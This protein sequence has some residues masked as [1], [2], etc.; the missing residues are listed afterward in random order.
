MRRNRQEAAVTDL[1][2]GGEADWQD[3]PPVR[4]L[5]RFWQLSLVMMGVGDYDG[6]YRYLNRAYRDVLGWSEE[7]LKSV[8]WWEFLHPD[9]RDQLADFA[10]QLM[11]HGR[12]RFGDNIRMLC[13]DGHYKW[14]QWNTASDPEAQLYY[15]VGVDMSDTYYCDERTAVGTWQWHVATQTLTLSSELCELLALPNSSPGWPSRARA[16]STS[17]SS[18]GGTVTARSLLQ[19]VHPEDRARV[20]LRARDSQI[21]GEAFAEDFRT[22]RADGAICWLHAAGRGTRDTAGRVNRVQGIALD[23][24]EHKN[25]EPA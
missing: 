10:Q 23:V 2:A 25:R 14:I 9:E 8:P 17:A 22:V 12:I 3:V 7:E 13:R 15:S 11:E 20:E 18:P 6:N 19:Q 4:D 5:M 16:R 1:A 24:T 21:T